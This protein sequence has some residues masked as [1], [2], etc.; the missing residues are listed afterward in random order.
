LG[1]RIHDRLDFGVSK[2]ILRGVIRDKVNGNFVVVIIIIIII[3]TTSSSDKSVG[4]PE[5]FANR[6]LSVSE[7]EGDRLRKGEIKS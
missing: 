5:M 4:I 6:I 2:I 3:T 7:C 1:E